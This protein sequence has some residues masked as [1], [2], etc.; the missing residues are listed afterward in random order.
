[1][2]KQIFII[3]GFGG[4]GKDTFVSY[5]TTELN[6]K[7]KRFNTVVN[8][9]SVDK[10][11]E[12]AREIGWNGG[13]TEKD[14]KFLSDLKVLAGNYNDMPFQS[15]RDKVDDFKTE[16]S[17]SILLF[18]HIREPEEISRAVKEF[19]AK[20][21]LMKRES[22]EHIISNVSDKNVFDYKYDYVIEN[23]G[24]KRELYETAKSFLKE[25]VFNE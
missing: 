23:N 6:D 12:I 11:K 21:I 24:D 16:D 10:I 2:D 3:N 8:F 18:L 4:V 22:V 19:S 7:V 15:L 13:K 5:V 17:K 20:T 1:M 25:V 14:R 9:S